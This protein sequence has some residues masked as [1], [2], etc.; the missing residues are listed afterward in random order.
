VNKSSG[1]ELFEE[2]RGVLEPVFGAAKKFLAKVSFLLL[3]FLWTIKEN[4]E[5]ID[6]NP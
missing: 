2:Q 4:E 1:I 6:N 3:R 5:I